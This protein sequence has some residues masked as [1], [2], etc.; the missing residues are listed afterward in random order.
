MADKYQ[1]PA[2]VALDPGKNYTGRTTGVVAGKRFV[3]FAAGGRSG[4]PY[5]AQSDATKAVVGVAKYDA[6]TNSEVGILTGGHVEVIAGGTI[7]VGDKVKSD[8]TGKAVKTT[9]QATDP[10]V[11]IAYTD[12]AADQSVYIQLSV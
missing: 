2:H 10:Y 4:K 3:S 8:A 12:A 11:G 6:P 1:N 9:T 5:V 7:A